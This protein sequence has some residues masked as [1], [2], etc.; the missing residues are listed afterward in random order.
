MVS[1]QTLATNSMDIEDESSKTCDMS[2]DVVITTDEVPFDFVLRV[3]S[4]T[5]CETH[6]SPTNILNI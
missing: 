4:Q 6:K 1:R 3:S 2:S 5:L